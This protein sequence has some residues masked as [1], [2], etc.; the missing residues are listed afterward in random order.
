MFCEESIYGEVIFMFMTKNVIMCNGQVHWECI[1][2]LNVV[3][4]VSINIMSFPKENMMYEDGL[5]LRSL[6]IAVCVVL[7]IFAVYIGANKIYSL[8]VKK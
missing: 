5:V 7:Q 8:I 3:F 4:H 2:T 1:L 6:K